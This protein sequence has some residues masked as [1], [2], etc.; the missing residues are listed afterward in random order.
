MIICQ[1]VRKNSYLVAVFSAFTFIINIIFASSAKADLLD[2]PYVLAGVG[3]ATSNIVQGDLVSLSTGSGGGFGGDLKQSPV[4]ALGAGASLP[5]DFRA[6]LTVSYRN[7]FHVASSAIDQATGTGFTASG[8]DSA[9]WTFLANLY[10]DI[11]VDLTLR[12]YVGFG[13]GW[14]SNRL[15]LVTYTAAGQFT[16][17]ENGQ[18]TGNFAWAALA[19]VRLALNE[20]WT[21]D[22]GYR[23]LNAGNF[24]SSGL[25]TDAF[26][27][28]ATDNIVKAKLV[29]NEGQLSLNYSF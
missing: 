6:D 18:T 10:Y 28:S 23:Y 27:N 22:L 24:R 19:G 11:P 17:S 29:T 3:G 15:G 2:H 1:S 25:V 20:D 7:K 14:A 8:N 4:Y 21:I 13:A 16:G 26:G 5:Y 9:N 12:P